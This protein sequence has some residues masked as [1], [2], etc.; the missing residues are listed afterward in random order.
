VIHLPVCVDVC[1]G[2]PINQCTKVFR[3]DACTGDGLRRG[4]AAIRS[5]EKLDRSWSQAWG[6]MRSKVRR[7]LCRQ[8]S[9]LLAIL[10]GAVV[11]DLAEFGDVNI[12]PVLSSRKQ[13]WE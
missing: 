8:N 1:R 11:W 4:P 9:G 7:F 12:L 2:V 5:G 10:P 13:S 6:G 3:T